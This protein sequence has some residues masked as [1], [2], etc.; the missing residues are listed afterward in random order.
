MLHGFQIVG[1]GGTSEVGIPNRGSILSDRADKGFIASSFDVNAAAAQI[2]LEEGSGGIALLYGVAYV[3]VKVKLLVYHYPEVLCLFD[4]LEV[5]N[6]VELVRV[7][8]VLEK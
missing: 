2:A 5:S 1:C 7:L 3:C 4:K 6:A 8:G